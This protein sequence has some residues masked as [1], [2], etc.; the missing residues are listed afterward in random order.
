[1]GWSADELTLMPRPKGFGDIHR[2]LAEQEASVV[3]ACFGM[4]ES[5]RGSEG[6]GQFRKDLDAFIQ[7]LQTHQYSSHSTPQ[8]VIVSPIAHEDLN[9][10]S[11]DAA[12]RNEEL[13]LYTKAMAEAAWRRNVLFV[14]LF[15]PT[16]ELMDSNPDCNLTFNGSHLTEYGY[17]KVSQIMAW[18]L[19]L[20][21][22]PAPPNVAGNATAESL[23][24]TIYEKNYYFFIRW[25]GPNAEYIHGERNQMGGA[26]N[27][28]EEM[29]EYDQIIDAYDRRIWAM[30]KPI[31]DQVWEQ[32]PQDNPVWHPTPQFK[33]T[34][35]RPLGPDEYQGVRVLSPQ[36][37]L[38]AF[39][40]PDGFAIKPFALE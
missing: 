2:Y 17:W 20:V 22:K 1:M 8:I 7:S 10:N 39:R 31:P 37:S 13:S 16:R 40:L 36:E 29:D 30:A 14:D 12:V 26:E 35:P 32:V 24:R 27:L 5:F 11:S 3:F 15:A 4:N 19:G 33:D 6:L 38:K 23:R 21:T 9:A 34:S 28:Q 18:S 25:R